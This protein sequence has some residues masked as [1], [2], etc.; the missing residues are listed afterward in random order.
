M[1][2]ISNQLSNAIA[3]RHVIMNIRDAIRNLSSHPNRFRKIDE[4]P[5]KS[6]GIRKIIVNHYYVYFWID[7]AN[8]EVHVISVTYSKRNQENFLIRITNNDLYFVSGV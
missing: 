4:Q 7:E 3:A 6:Q 2:E 1:F 5:W 8:L